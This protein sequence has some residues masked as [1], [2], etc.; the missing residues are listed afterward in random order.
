LQHLTFFTAGMKKEERL[1]V[2]KANLTLNL[3]KKALKNRGTDARSEILKVNDGE[4][5][6]Y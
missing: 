6:K 2:F 3:K 1:F 4:I 5:K